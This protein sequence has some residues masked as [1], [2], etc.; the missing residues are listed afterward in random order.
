MS[1]LSSSSK[2]HKDR[3]RTT[4]VRLRFI[5]TFPLRNYKLLGVYKMDT[6]FIFPSATLALRTSLCS[7]GMYYTWDLLSHNIRHP[8]TLILLKGWSVA[9]KAMQC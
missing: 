1:T 5:W 7:G 8:I 2:Y 6:G 9:L 4:A 3:M